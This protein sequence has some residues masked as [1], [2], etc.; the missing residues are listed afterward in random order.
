MVPRNT[1]VTQ[2]ISER[3]GKKKKTNRNESKRNEKLG[4]KKH[5]T[6]MAD[7]C[8]IS[9]WARIHEVLALALTTVLPA[10]GTRPGSEGGSRSTSEPSKLGSASTFTSYSPEGNP[11]DCRHAA[12][13]RRGRLRKGG[14]EGREG[15]REGRRGEEGTTLCLWD[16]KKKVRNTCIY[17]R[18][19]G[20]D[21]HA[22]IFNHPRPPPP[23]TPA[24]EGYQLLPFPPPPRDAH[25]YT[26]P[27]SLPPMHSMLPSIRRN[28]R[29]TSDSC[30]V[31]CSP[32]FLRLAKHLTTLL[33]LGASKMSARS[34][35]TLP[36]AVST[37]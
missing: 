21:V 33:A 25:Y 35:R 11:T 4:G 3:R 32:R 22:R 20:V 27:L 14:G 2:K 17:T 37:L 16:T 15:G 19:R 8:M 10:K 18:S 1:T 30:I 5:K 6:K 23:H 36:C 34:V 12:D 9:S 24:K 28:A 13:G 29:L 26:P 31:R 7:T